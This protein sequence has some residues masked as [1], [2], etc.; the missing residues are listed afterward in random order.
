[1]PINSNKCILHTFPN[2]ANKT[3]I[4][5]H[6]ETLRRKSLVK[7]A[8][9]ALAAGSRQFLRPAE[10][11]NMELIYGNLEETLISNTFSTFY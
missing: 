10:V 8:G 6:F 4:P 1:M 9:D 11:T 5:K 3:K 7:N 2:M